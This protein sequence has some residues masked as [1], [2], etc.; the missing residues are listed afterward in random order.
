M[1]SEIH[2]IRVRTVHS[3]GVRSR[4][5]GYGQYT[6]GKRDPDL[7]GKDGTQLGSE[8]QITRVRTVHSWKDRSRL[9]G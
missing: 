3:W 1:W 9:P 4:L 2:N 7:Q 6:G 8:I 5:P